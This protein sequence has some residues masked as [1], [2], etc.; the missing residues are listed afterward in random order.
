[1]TFCEITYEI[2]NKTFDLIFF[3][4]CFTAF[5]RYFKVILEQSVKPNLNVNDYA[6]WTDQSDVHTTHFEF[7]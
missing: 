2:L 4:W 6:V 7:E 5:V 1:M 3:F